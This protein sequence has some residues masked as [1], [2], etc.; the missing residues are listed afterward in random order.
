[1]ARKAWFALNIRNRYVNRFAQSI[2]I[3]R[4]GTTATATAATDHEIL[5]GGQVVISGATQAEYNGTFD[6]TVTGATTFTFTVTG[7]PATPATG[8]I[9][10]TPQIWYKYIRPVQ[11]PFD[12]GS[13]STGRPW[14]KFNVES[15]K[16]PS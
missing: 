10:A 3:T 15:N 14:V 1:M 7:T 5:D 11:E 12:A 6:V 16:R 4:S 13:D 8:T 9:V 2:T